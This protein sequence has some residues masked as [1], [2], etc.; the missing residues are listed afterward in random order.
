MH[1]RTHTRHILFA[2]FLSLVPLVPFFQRLTWISAWR[3]SVLKRKQNKRVFLK[4][5]RS[6]N[7]KALA[8]SPVQ[9]VV[10]RCS[11]SGHTLNITSSVIST[12]EVLCTA[13]HLDTAYLAHLRV[14]T[15]VSLYVCVFMH[16]P[17]CCEC[18]DLPPST[19][20]QP[21]KQP[22]NQTT[23]Q[24]TSQ[25]TNQ[26]S[27]KPTNQATKQ[28]TNQPTKQPA[29][30]PTNQ[31]NYQATK[32]TTD[33]P[34]NQPTNQPN[35]QATKQPSNQSTNQLTNQPTH[36]PTKQTSNEPTNQPNKLPSNKPTNQPTKQP[37]KLRTY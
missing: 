31:L 6:K 2:L 26:P 35:Y 20:P 28:P 15:Y 12:A 25:P 22:N 16:L 36:P 5:Q 32:Q 27:N 33:E 7:E 9:S 37:T 23:S 17:A 11:I 19:L 34:T 1:T 18:T 21:T 8:V 4:R 13:D 29:N 3:A 10:H 14:R 24:P 30:Q